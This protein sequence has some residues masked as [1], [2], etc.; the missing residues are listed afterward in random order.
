MPYYE[1]TDRP[2]AQELSDLPTLSTGQAEDLKSEW[3]GVCFWLS[4]CGLEDREP[5]ENTISIE[6]QDFDGWVLYHR[7]DGGTI[8]HG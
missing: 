2:T 6:V 1:R 8:H 3:S 7:Y 4:R 5:F